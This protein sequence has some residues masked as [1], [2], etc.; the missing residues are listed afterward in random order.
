L[1]QK[2]VVFGRLS[3][4]R[5]LLRPGREDRT[6][7]SPSYL[8]K[9]IG[10]AGFLIEQVLV[11]KVFQGSIILVQDHGFSEPESQVEGAADLAVQ[12]G[13]GPLGAS[14]RVQGH[15]PVSGLD[16]RMEQVIG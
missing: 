6:K 8:E 10:Q 5:K 13:R 16:A 11:P 12:V 15:D 2:S 9:E 1:V 14:P 7:L 3:F 4:Q